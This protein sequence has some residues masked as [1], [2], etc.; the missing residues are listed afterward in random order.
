MITERKDDL[1]FVEAESFIDKLLKKYLSAK[2]GDR[3]VDNGETNSQAGRDG[4]TDSGG[5]GNIVQQPPVG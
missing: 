5:I 2:L 4:I 1:I 3:E